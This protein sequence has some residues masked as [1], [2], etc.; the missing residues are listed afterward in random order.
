M[1]THGRALLTLAHRATADYD[2]D[3][4]NLCESEVLCPMSARPVDAATGESER[5]YCDVDDMATNRP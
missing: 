1:T 2:E 3:D 5:G 4:D